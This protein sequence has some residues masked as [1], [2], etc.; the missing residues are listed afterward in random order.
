VAARATTVSAATGVEHKVVELL[1]V[2]DADIEAT[3]NRLAPE[4]WQLDRVD[5]V[6]EPGVRRPQMAFL[7]FQRP[8]T[9]T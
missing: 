1:A 3:L 2:T 9:S 4:G 5:Y 7:Y 8:R 6:K